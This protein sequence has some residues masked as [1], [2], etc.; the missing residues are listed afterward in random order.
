MHVAFYLYFALHPSIHPSTCGCMLQIVMARSWL[1]ALPEET[2]V[3]MPCE[4]RTISLVVLSSSLTQTLWLLRTPATLG[5]CLLVA[6][7]TGQN[8]GSFFGHRFKC[9]RPRIIMCERPCTR[10]TRSFELIRSSISTKTTPS[11]YEITLRLSPSSSSSS[12]SLLMMSMDQMSCCCVAGTKL[13]LFFFCHAC[14]QIP[15]TSTSK[16]CV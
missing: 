16:S 5:S 15:A 3:S 13:K 4:V 11:K 10:S 8:V 1:E 12:S 6:H 2:P 9:S 7:C 14:L